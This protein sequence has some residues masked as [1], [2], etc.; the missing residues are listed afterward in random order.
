MCSRSGFQSCLLTVVVIVCSFEIWRG[1]SHTT[2]C[3]ARHHIEKE[4]RTIYKSMMLAHLYEPYV[5]Y[6]HF[7]QTQQLI[8]YN[9]LF[10]KAATSLLTALENLVRQ[11][12]VD[13]STIK[14]YYYATI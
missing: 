4:W 6:I 14:L 1:N 7:F 3:M 9:L 5:T 13:L 10:K 12:T 8:V 2:S 11:L